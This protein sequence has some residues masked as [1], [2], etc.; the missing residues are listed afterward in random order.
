MIFLSVIV[1]PIIIVIAGFVQS[2]SSFIF[3]HFYLLLT[4]CQEEEIL[5]H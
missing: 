3:H 5:M 1:L 2:H 4:R